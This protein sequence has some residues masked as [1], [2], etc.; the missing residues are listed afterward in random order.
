[1][2]LF[3]IATLLTAP[4][5]P[6][7][8]PASPVAI[9]QGAV[10]SVPVGDPLRRTLLDALRGPVEAELDQPVLFVVDQLKVQGDWA[11]YAG[12]VQAPGG[13]PI[14]FARA[15]YAEAIAE[16]VFDG[17]ATYGLLRRQGGRWTVVVHV[18]G[19]TDVAWLGWHDEYGAPNALFE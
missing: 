1:M 6:G 16:G 14:D 18:I 11:F 7:A 8:G 9:S 2:S 19:P 4:V 3:L 5:T 17:P 10:R 15:G 12:E 13:R